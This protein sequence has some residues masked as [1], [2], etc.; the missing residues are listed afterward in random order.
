MNPRLSIWYATDPL[1][2]K[3]PNISSY[4]YCE[5][6]PII[7]VDVNGNWVKGVNGKRVYY[8]R[9]NQLV[10]ASKDFLVDA[11][12]MSKTSKGR[13]ILKKMLDS[14]Y[15][16]S[17][18]YDNTNSPRI[19]NKYILGKTEIIV[20]GDKIDHAIITVYKKNIR[21]HAKNTSRYKDLT[22]EEI[23][24]SNMAHEG[25]HGTEKAAMSRFNKNSEQNAIKSE[26]YHL[27]ELR[28][29]KNKKTLIRKK[30]K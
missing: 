29:Q 2:E 18:S 3:Y 11:N 12:Q 8:N 17:I 22:T 26:N 27:R 4:A 20:K 10:N 30:K 16:I 21:N 9:N 19:K 7:Y 14:S 1:Q 6:N 24:G 25:T 28:Q 5:G 23:R 15:M 13:E